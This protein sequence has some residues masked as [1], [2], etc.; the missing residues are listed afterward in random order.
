MVG[1]RH[2]R[3]LLPG[4][5]RGHGGLLHAH[6]GRHPNRKGMGHPFRH[7]DAVEGL[8]AVVGR[9]ANVAGP[10]P[11]DRCHHV[12]HFGSHHDLG[13]V[14]DTRPTSA[15][16][17]PLP[18]A[19]GHSCD[20][21]RG[22][23]GAHLPRAGHRF[24]PSMRP[25]C[26]SVTPSASRLPPVVCSPSTP[27]G[28]RQL[29]KLGEHD[30]GAVTEVSQGWPADPSPGN[31]RPDGHLLPT[32]MEQSRLI[33]LRRRDAFA[34]GSTHQSGA[35]LVKAE[36]GFEVMMAEFQVRGGPG[37]R[38]AGTFMINPPHFTQR[39]TTICCPGVRALER[40]GAGFPRFR[41]R[42]RLVRR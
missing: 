15:D 5:T 11:A 21:A 40:P 38:P 6:P 26:R 7:P 8:P 23:I 42:W 22:G 35:R 27:N 20:C 1:S 37:V 17:I 32:E 31:P 41:G 9:V 24:R 36:R 30:G 14:V 39:P 13:S 2:H 4:P 3:R 19:S 28:D 29:A 10:R 33:G 34:G 12:G 25:H 16:G 18:P